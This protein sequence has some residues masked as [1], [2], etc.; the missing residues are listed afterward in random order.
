MGQYTMDGGNIVNSLKVDRSCATIGLPCCAPGKQPTVS[1]DNSFQISGLSDVLEKLD[2]IFRATGCPPFPLCILN[3]FIGL[4][5]TIPVVLLLDN[6]YWSNLWMPWGLPINIYL[7][8]FGTLNCQRKKKIRAALQE[9]NST[10][11][12][13][14]GLSLRLGVDEVVDDRA[15][16]KVI[17]PCCKGELEAYIHVCKV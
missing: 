10:I 17:C 2:K 4:A 5:V 13:K 15:F 3:V 7:V 1:K 14:Q 11:G 16:W 9:W 8:I 6:K 12:S